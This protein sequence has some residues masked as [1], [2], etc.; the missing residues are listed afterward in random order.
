MSM[1]LGLCEKRLQKSIF[2]RNSHVSLTL[3]GQT[4]Y[5]CMENGRSLEVFETNGV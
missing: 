3:I 4:V 2:A 5:F 1:W